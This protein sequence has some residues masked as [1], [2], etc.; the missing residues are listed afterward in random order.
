MTTK[1]NLSLSH[2]FVFLPLAHLQL[3]YKQKKVNCGRSRFL[4]YTQWESLLKRTSSSPGILVYLQGVLEKDYRCR[5]DFFSPS[6]GVTKKTPDL[7][8]LWL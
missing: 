2:S 5:G 4:R 7:P 1:E 6:F 8:N 3:N